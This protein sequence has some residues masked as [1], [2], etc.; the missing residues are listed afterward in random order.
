[1]QQHSF[2]I[3]LVRFLL[4]HSYLCINVPVRAPYDK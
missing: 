4:I 1:V 3:F 2:H